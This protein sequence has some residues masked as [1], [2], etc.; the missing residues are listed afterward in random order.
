MQPPVSHTAQPPVITTARLVLRPITLQDAPAHNR[1]M[2]DWEIVR[3]FASTF[4]HPYA[5]D[6]SE[7][8]IDYILTQDAVIYW[9]IALQSAPDIMIGS[10]E[11][12]PQA[13]RGQRAFWLDRAHH[14]KGYV[15][16]AATAVNDYWFDVLGKD[17]LHMEN[18]L[19]N[20]ASRRIKEKTGAVFMGTRPSA[21]VDPLLDTSE[22]WLLKKEDWHRFRGR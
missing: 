17:T 5:D 3:N 6:G 9:A 18:A 15:T 8:F 20:I 19:G 10:I 2:K 14:N 4:P 11:L 16:E 22:V 21:H 7:K 12:R 13:E 1:C